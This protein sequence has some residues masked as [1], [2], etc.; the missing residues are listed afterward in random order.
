MQ[1][2]TF[3]CEVDLEHLLVLQLPPSVSP[4]RHRISLVID[5]PEASGGDRVISPIGDSVPPRT[6]LWSQLAALREQAA[7]EGVLPEPLSWDGV[8][9][10]SE[11][12]R[13]DVDD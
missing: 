8:L 12:R 10:E 1:T 2:L 6:A 13:G 9:A 4:G 3:E 5:P 11:R 7:R